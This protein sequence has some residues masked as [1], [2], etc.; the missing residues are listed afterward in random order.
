MAISEADRKKQEAEF[1]NERERDRQ[2]M[3]EEEWLQKYSN[4]KWY[5]ITRRS[6]DFKTDLLRRL[7]PS[8]VALDYCC[9]LGGTSLALAEGG[10]TVHGIDI[11][12]E[13]VNTAAKLLRDNGFGETSHFHVMDAEKLDFEDQ[14][15]DLIVCSG[16]LHHLDVNH[17]FPELARVLKPSGSIVCIEALGYNPIIRLYRR[18]TPKLRT[19]WEIDHIL[20]LREVGLARRHFGKVDVRYF[21]LLSILAVPLRRTRFFGTTLSVLE[22]LDGLLLRIP[23]IQRLAW[24]MIFVLREPQ[25]VRQS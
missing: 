24:Q 14:M 17:A 11:S 25:R 3:S 22:R 18:L 10:A 12:Q 21:H 7:A 8:A 9:G 15:F 20:T 13:S 1:H 19:A 23:G 6:R 16:V 2:T 4:K 5:A